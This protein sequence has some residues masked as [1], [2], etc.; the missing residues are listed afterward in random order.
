MGALFSGSSDICLLSG[1]S[2]VLAADAKGGKLKMLAGAQLLPSYAVFSKRP[3]IKTIKDLEGKTVATGSVGALLYQLM[4]AILQKKGVDISKVK[5]VNAGSSANVFRAVAAGTV[6]AG[7]SLYDVY[8]QQAKYGVH[9]LEDGNLWTELPEYTYQGSYATETAIAKKRDALVRVLAAYCKAY[10]YIQSPN[11]LDDYVA[12]RRAALHGDPKLA[13]AEA[14]S[15]WRFNQKFKPY[16]TELVLSKERVDYMQ[17][18]NISLGAQKDML[19][20]EQVADMSLAHDA[21]KLLG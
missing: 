4:A 20:Y 19:P 6:D 9:A 10:R 3:E 11:S 14:S 13:E 7:P 12:A 21:L 16:A 17:K 5:F 1:F 15:E 8:E 2:Q 18:L